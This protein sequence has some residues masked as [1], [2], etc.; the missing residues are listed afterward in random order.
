[1]V[2]IP[3]Q[4]SD[5][6]YLKGKGRSQINPWKRELSQ[7][8][9]NKEENCCKNP[10]MEE[11]ECEDDL[12]REVEVENEHFREKEKVKEGGLEREKER[13]AVERAI[14]EARER[15]FA[16]ARERAAN[17]RAA[18]VAHQRLKAE[19]RER[20]EKAP[21]EVNNKSAAEKASFEAKLKAERAAVERATAEAR[22]RALEKAL[23]NGMN[24]RDKQYNDPDPSSSSRYP[25]S[26][27]HG[28]SSN[29][30][31][32]ESAQ[33]SS[34]AMLERDQRTAERAAKALAE[35]NMRDLL[36]KKEQAERNILGPDSGWQSIP[37]TELV[38]STAVKKAYRK[39]TLFVHPDKLQ[40]RGASIQQK[41]TCE[42]VFDLLKDAWNKLSA[43]ER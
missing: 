11:K 12:K 23:A 3:K 42:K 40:Q 18:A 43:E 21:S 2:S 35:K 28:E 9:S 36:A 15:A 33:R 32:G 14:R 27:N 10:A 5:L 30:G 16:E 29:G 37:L 38:S 26:S 20:L 13:I 41:Y 4:P 24:S 17:E 25:G 34:K 8:T 22:Q 1:M 31:D 7:S 6:V 39:A 19:V